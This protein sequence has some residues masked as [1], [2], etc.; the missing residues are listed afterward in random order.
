MVLP[1]RARICGGKRKF[2]AAETRPGCANS[3]Q[4][5]TEPSPKSIQ[6]GRFDG[7]PHSPLPVAAACPDG[8]ACADCSNPTRSTAEA[9]SARRGFVTWTY[10]AEL[11]DA[12]EDRATR[13][14]HGLRTARDE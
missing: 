14:L 12:S 4:K 1:P 5:G 13:F 11:W 7:K 2:A 10:V 9:A 8:A 3:S 6:S